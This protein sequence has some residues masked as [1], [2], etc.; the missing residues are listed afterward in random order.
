[1][2]EATL[3]SDI[4]GYRRNALADEAAHLAELHR[5]AAVLVAE[6]ERENSRLAR[7]QDWK[8]WLAFCKKASEQPLTVSAD[9]LVLYAAW[10]ANDAQGPL[11]PA[12]ILRRLAGVLYGWRKSGLDYPRHVAE[13][14]RQVVDGHERRLHKQSRPVGRGQ[15][16]AIPLID[17]QRICRALP[18]SIA[19]VRDRALILV[20][21]GI[22]ARRSELSHLEVSDV[23]EDPRGIHV[24][25]R[26][27]KKR[28]RRPGVP[29]GDHEKT[30][31]VT[32][33]RAWLEV[34]GITDG[35][36]FRQVDRHSRIGGRM[37]PR[38]V[39]DAITRAGENAK[40]GVRYTGHSLRSG[41]ATEA[42]L[43]GHDVV[44]I[45][46]QG[47]WAENSS[48]LYGYIRTVDKWTD[49][50]VKGIGL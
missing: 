31:P 48:S 15:A 22:A 19:G 32:A 16:P 28:P 50:A 35:P 20:G 49:N 11:A 30:C 39:G 42:R 45:A 5:D 27:T 46:R 18:D 21:F 23:T 10:L 3:A 47:G 29:Y 7:E 34:S 38:A 26:Y 25:V 40:L 6:Q 41:L 33:W 13:Q 44:A 9:V 12:S 1:M 14:A 17:L 4:A 8:T 36:A 24:N 43:A 2:N 37:S